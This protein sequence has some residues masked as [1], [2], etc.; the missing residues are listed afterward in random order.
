M[1]RR[2]DGSTTT[3]PTITAGQGFD[4]LVLKI[5]GAVRKGA[6]LLY[7]LAGAPGGRVCFFFPVFT[8]SKVVEGPTAV[9]RAPMRHRAFGVLIEGSEEAFDAFLLVEAKAPIQTQVEPALGFRRRRRHGPAV[10]PEVEVIHLAVRLFVLA[11]KAP[12]CARC[13]ALDYHGSKKATSIMAPPIHSR[14][15]R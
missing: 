2:C 8:P 13:N 6:R 12:S 7:V 4:Q 14:L 11:A 1:R 15:P 3:I 9:G 10:R 5:C